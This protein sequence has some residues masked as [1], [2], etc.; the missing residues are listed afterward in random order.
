MHHRSGGFSSAALVPLCECAGLGFQEEIVYI[1][2]PHGDETYFK[3]AKKGR[4]SLCSQALQ[5]LG[6]PPLQ[7]GAGTASDAVQS[8]SQDGEISRVLSIID[9]GNAT[10]GH[11]FRVAKCCPSVVCSI[12]GRF[13]FGR[14]AKG[15][16]ALCS[17]GR[18]RPVLCVG[19]AERTGPPK[20]AALRQWLQPARRRRGS[21]RHTDGVMG[22]A[23]TGQ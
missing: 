11:G 16:L 13:A 18:G 7:G 9:V 21:G 12:C 4:P 14:K 5:P 6:V 17:M 15:R 22:V 10:Q 8:L 23:V 1:S 19:G 3:S 2:G 20:P